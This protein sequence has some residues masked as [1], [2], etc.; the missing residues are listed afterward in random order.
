MTCLTDNVSL[1]RDALFALCRSGTPSSREHGGKLLRWVGFG[2]GVLGS[3]I[4]LTLWFLVRPLLILVT[5]GSLLSISLKSAGALG[6]LFLAVRW[7]R[8]RLQRLA[9]SR[10]WVS[11][12]SMRQVEALRQAHEARLRGG[13]LELID[14]TSAEP[15]ALDTTLD[16]PRHEALRATLNRLAV[17]RWDILAELMSTGS[18]LPDAVLYAYDRAAVP[19]MRSALSLEETSPSASA[20]AE[21]IARVIQRT[22]TLVERT[23]ALL[24]AQA[25]RRAHA[26]SAARADESAIADAITDAITDM[27]GDQFEEGLAQLE[28]LIE[29]DR[30]L[31]G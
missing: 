3:G 18:L 5:K 6:A 29:S 19:L 7:T 27:A 21:A 11:L 23:E 20:R 1:P 4:A 8:R 17:C 28:A 15:D 22:R 30:E 14:E 16:D 12:R 25:H 13:L 31:G 24:Q 10:P 9:E 26:T 2:K